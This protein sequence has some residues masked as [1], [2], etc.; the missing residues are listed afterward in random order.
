MLSTRILRNLNVIK[1][2]AM[3]FAGCESSPEATQSMLKKMEAKLTK[4]F[5]PVQCHVVDPYGDMNSVQIRVVSEK[6]KGMLPLARHR[7]I[8]EVLKEEIK[9]I[10]AVQIDAKTPL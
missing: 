3:R 7:A 8:N 9:L 4:E 2:P 5:E 10:H 6:F 1:T